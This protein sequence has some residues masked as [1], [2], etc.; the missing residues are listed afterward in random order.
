MTT[1]TASID[2]PGTP[3][4]W[5]NAAVR[6]LLRI[7]GVRAWIGKSFAV[8]TVVGAKSGRR[9][10]TPVQYMRDQG[11]L[12]V[13]SQRKRVWW[14]NLRIHPEVELRIGARTIRGSGHVA[15]EAVAHEIAARCL[16]SYPSI[17]KFYGIEV[18]SG[19]I[20]GALIDE[21]L[22]HIVVLVIHPRS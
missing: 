2:L 19:G 20:D 6:T 3:P 22:R 21:L 16:G 4:A 10:T 5:V 18:A 13:L 7:P 8:I 14:R 12:V 17:A 1:R 15:E 9:Y 11:D